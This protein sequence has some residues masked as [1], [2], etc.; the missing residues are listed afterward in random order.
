[1]S[2]ARRLA[3]AVLFA[4]ALTA[5]GCESKKG[6]ERGQ[7]VASAKMPV[8]IFVDDR[9]VAGELELGG[10]P[11]PIAE[12]VAG[13]P[14]LDGWLALEVIDR[15]GKVH[16]IMAPARNQ[17]GKLPVLARG[18]DGAELGFRTPCAKGPLAD[19]VRGVTRVTI[20]T[21]SDRG[22]IA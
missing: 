16:T 13:A 4:A 2:I 21:R 18:A 1:M 12:L 22:Q 7:P 8:A 19:A 20:K 6:S 9:Q 11:R 3:S 17:P 14:P 10:E 5:P 15:A